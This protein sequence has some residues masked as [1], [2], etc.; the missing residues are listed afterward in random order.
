MV[1][2]LFA[3][4]TNSLC[5]QSLRAKKIQGEYQMIVPEDISLKQAKSLAI[6][7]AR[8]EALK[9]AFGEV[10]IQ[11]NSTYLSSS[12]NNE[13]SDSKQLFNM[14]AESYVNGEWIKDREPPKIITEQLAGTQE[15][16]IRAKVKGYGRALPERKIS[17]EFQLHSNKATSTQRFSHGDDFFVSIKSS[18][19]GYLYLFMDDLEN[20]STSLIFPLGRDITG[21]ESDNLIEANTKV[22]LF[23][24]DSKKAKYEIGAYK[25]NPNVIETIKVYFLFS[26]STPLLLPDVSPDQGQEEILVNEY[27]IVP[28]VNMPMRDFQTW[29]HSLRRNNKDLEYDWS[30]ITIE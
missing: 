7:Q 25:A 29:L 16:W 22:N 13:R 12:L 23:R 3:L 14:I 2:T 28:L 27:T 19:P 26:P 10:I 4:S 9:S 15:M 6:T 5:A 1:L 17:F 20:Q 21:V 30:V 11:G 8:I 18:I 24:K